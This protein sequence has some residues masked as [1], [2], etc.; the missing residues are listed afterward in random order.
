MVN[1]F[2]YFGIV[3]IILLWVGTIIGMLRSGLSLVDTR[4]ISYIGVATDSAL[5]FN[6]LLFLSA[7]CFVLF[8]VYLYKSIGLNK[9]F[10]LVFL[11]GQIGQMIA[12][13]LPYGGQYKIVHTVA[14]F[15]LATAIP[16]F[17]YIFSKSKSLGNFKTS[18]RRLFIAEL[19]FFTV[20]ISTF[21]FIDGISPIAEIL[22]ALPFHLW[23]ILITVWIQKKETWT[24]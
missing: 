14:A 2:R 12:A 11:I 5:F 8:G 10:L 3:G 6:S 19:I 21:I 17:M 1:K 7:V 15:T 23:I 20:G 4:P 9:S 24:R 22:P 13:I 18:A 16:I